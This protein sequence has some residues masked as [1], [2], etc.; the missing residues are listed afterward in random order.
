VKVYENAVTLFREYCI[1]TYNFAEIY[2]YMQH[3][4]PQ[5]LG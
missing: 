5:W 4:A 2:E 3:L 1:V